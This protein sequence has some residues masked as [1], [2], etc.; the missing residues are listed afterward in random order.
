MANS[1]RGE[2]L[3]S[4]RGES[5]AQCAWGDARAE[6]S[7]LLDVQQLRLRGVARRQALH[8]PA[9][10]KKRA[11]NGRRIG[12]EAPSP[13]PCARKPVRVG[14]LVDQGEHTVAERR[15]DEVLDELA[16]ARTGLRVASAKAAM[17]VCEFLGRMEEPETQANAVDGVALVVAKNR[18]EQF[19]TGVRRGSPGAIAPSR[20]SLDA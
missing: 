16:A 15:R 1:A 14:T 6:P 13:L 7:H 5:G 17:D 11:Q 10:G 9:P 3:A 8:V 2:Y 19:E 18:D 4:A 20:A 12:R